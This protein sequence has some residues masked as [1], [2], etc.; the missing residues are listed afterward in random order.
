MIFCL[1]GRVTLKPVSGI[2]RYDS[3]EV[4][5]IRRR[6]KAS[7]LQRGMSEAELGWTSSAFDPDVL[8][9]GFA[10][11]FATY[12]RATLLFSD[13]ARVKKPSESKEPWDYLDIVKTVKG[14]DAYRPV[15]ESKCPLLKK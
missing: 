6:I 5:E 4:G 2:R 9:I 8:T 10:R 12:K 7:G 3:L 14:D 13:L 1:C 15:S 11:R